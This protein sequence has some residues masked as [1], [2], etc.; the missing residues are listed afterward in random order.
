MNKAMQ[1]AARPVPRTLCA[2]AVAAALPVAAQAPE[3]DADDAETA[4]T[5]ELAAVEAAVTIE[6][7]LEEITTVERRQQTGERGVDLFGQRT[8]EQDR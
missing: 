6:D 7:F 8:H 3:E 5:Q 1:A 4:D 2:L